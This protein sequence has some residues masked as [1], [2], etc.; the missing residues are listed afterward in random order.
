MASQTSSA[1]RRV[2]LIMSEID[3][4][5]ARV[6]VDNDV[7]EL[8]YHCVCTLQFSKEALITARNAM[9]SAS[10]EVETWRTAFPALLAQLDTAIK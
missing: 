3:T 6:C 10:D 4:T 2:E 1:L 8:L 9:Q 5:L 7:E